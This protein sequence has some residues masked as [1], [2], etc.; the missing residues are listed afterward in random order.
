MQREPLS[1]E[2]AV[3]HFVAAVVAFSEDPGPANLERY[4]R[5]SRSLEE[6][7]SG[8]VSQRNVSQ[9]KRVAGAPR[10]VAQGGAAAA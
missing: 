3:E 6:S 7:R 8:N 9:R 4:L 5:A 2:A 1:H 10:R